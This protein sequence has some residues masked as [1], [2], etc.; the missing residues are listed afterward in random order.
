MSEDYQK[1]ANVSK[2]DSKYDEVGNPDPRRIYDP[3]NKTPKKSSKNTR[4]KTPKVVESNKEDE[5]KVEVIKKSFFSP[6]L[7]ILSV[8]DKALSDC[9]YQ[10]MFGVHPQ[11]SEMNPEEEEGT[12]DPDQL[13]EMIMRDCA[14]SIIDMYKKNQID[15][16]TMIYASMV[17]S[18]ILNDHWDMEKD[19]EEM[20]RQLIPQAHLDA[21]AE[22]WEKKQ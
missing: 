9:L 19:G 15:H 11:L 12:L 10:V 16:Q 5:E 18:P 6:E 21:L 2:E 20:V 22:R 13:K 1:V 4:T 3:R 7:H 14:L 17:I 8:A